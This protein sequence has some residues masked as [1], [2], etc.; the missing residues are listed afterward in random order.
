MSDDGG[1]TGQIAAALAEHGLIPRGGFV[2]EAGE[3]APPGPSGRAARSLLLI[4]QAGAA[5]WRHFERWREAQ[6]AGLENPLDSWSRQVIGQVANDFGAR[7][8]SPSD[9]P[10]LPFQQW[11]MRAEGLRPSP[12]GIL[13]HPQY[14][15]W[16]AYR[17]ALLFDVEIEIPEVR[18]QSHLCD[19][20]VGK[21][22]LK[23]CPVGAY[24]VAGFAYEDCL[25]HVRG[26][27]GGACRSSG[28]LDRNACPQGLA[29]R[30]P[31][32][33]QAFHMKSFAG[34]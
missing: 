19:L 20:C 8:V 21:P 18:G 26:P 25:A 29:Y 3:E 10:H 33:V 2:F 15:L 9:R 6:P 16:H 17:G 22:C 28:C 4:G 5:P 13:M 31:E 24:S 34:L 14:G 30:Y 11:A 23:S 32:A 12:L 7:V 1:P 27:A